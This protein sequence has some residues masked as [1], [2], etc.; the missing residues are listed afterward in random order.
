LRLNR[1]ATEHLAR[2]NGQL[3]VVDNLVM[4]GGQVSHRFVGGR[5]TPS[6]PLNHHRA[7]DVDHWTEDA[8]NNTRHPVLLHFD[9]LLRPLNLK[10]TFWRLA[11]GTFAFG[12]YLHVD[13]CEV[14]LGDVLRLLLYPSSFCPSTT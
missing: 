9:V 7:K 13:G 1:S 14:G 12:P 2:Q 10:V 11:Q 5:R 3:T 6:P 8:P 4:S